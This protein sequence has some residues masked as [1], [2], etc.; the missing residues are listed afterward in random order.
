MHV[1]PG[2][3]S[4]MTH[5]IER[6]RD[7]GETLTLTALR[8]GA[9]VILVAHGLQKLM[10]IGGTAQA[11]AGMG[12]PSPEISV[13]LAILGELVGGFGLL[14]GLFTRVAALGPLCTMIVAIF[15]VHL[16]KG[17]F[18]QQG[19]WEYPLT[20]LLVSLYFVAR[21]GGPISVDHALR[22]LRARRHGTAARRV[23]PAGTRYGSP[24]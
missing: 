6:V 18:A 21:G 13:Y 8:V 20:L 3:E 2:K 5:R 23:P 24:A 9:G 19:G 14:I 17:L 15:F 16:G 22:E 10:D 11:F 7:A 4:H 12:I 1:A